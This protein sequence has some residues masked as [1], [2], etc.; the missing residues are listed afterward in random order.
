MLSEN[1]LKYVLLATALLFQFILLSSTSFLEI[2]RGSMTQD[3]QYNAQAVYLMGKNNWNPHVYNDAFPSRYFDD[4]NEIG[5][6]IFGLLAHFIPSIWLLKVSQDIGTI[7]SSLLV[8]LL[9]DKVANDLPS[10]LLRFCVRGT[11]LALLV[12]SPWP[13]WTNGFDVH[14]QTLAIPF[15]I[16]AVFFAERQK[17]IACIVSSMLAISFGD[18]VATYMVALGMSIA[19]VRRT[20]TSGIFIILISAAMFGISTRLK[21]IHPNGASIGLFYGYVLDSGINVSHA[22]FG[23]ILAGALRHPDRVVACI[24]KQGPNIWANLAPTGIVGFLHPAAFGISVITLAEAVLTGS[25]LF[26]QPGF[27][28]GVIYPLG[29][30]G[31]SYF[32]VYLMKRNKD[33]GIAASFLLTLNVGLWAIVF[34]PI[35]QSHW[36]RVTELQSKS[37]QKVKKSIATGHQIIV[38]QG[39]VGAFSERIHVFPELSLYSYFLN[40]PTD[41]ILSPYA[42]INFFTPSQFS[43]EFNFLIFTMHAHVIS[44]TNDIW[45]FSL[46]NWPPETKVPPMQLVD[47]NDGNR[48]FPAYAFHAEAG[49]PIIRASSQ[50]SF[51]RANGSPGYIVSEVYPYLAPGAYHISTRYRSN[52]PLTLEIYDPYQQRFIARRF[53]SKTKG[54]TE[55]GVDIVIGLE[56]D[57]TNDLDAGLGPFQFLP[58]KNYAGLSKLEMRIHNP[59]GTDANIYGFRTSHI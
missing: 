8:Y 52:G 47:V 40:E 42:G 12:L 5:M 29:A 54:V 57:S 25:A 23:S 28:N 13:Y 10:P 31:T 7:V 58:L 46:P 49:S 1:W 20:R 59:G 44:H 30:L 35:V 4:H 11:T 45:H 41:I 18:V 37:L 50:T 27:Q 21:A 6:I 51:M 34:L 15:I 53:L 39:V 9:V 36:V 56:T 32:L 55:S 22:G 16:A 33:A 19:C 38:S 24:A 43:D 2:T 17:M 3:L 26:A 14:V 48:Y